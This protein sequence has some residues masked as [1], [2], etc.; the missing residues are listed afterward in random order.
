MNRK[1][2]L[3]LHDIHGQKSKRNDI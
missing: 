2:F 3:E 1:V